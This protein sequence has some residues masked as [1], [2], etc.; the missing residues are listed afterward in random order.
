MLETG[1]RGREATLVEELLVELDELEHQSDVSQVK[2]S[3]LLFQMEDTLPPVNVIFL[4]R[5]IDRLGELADIS[6]K[7]GGRL[8]LLIAK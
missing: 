4:Y 5:I 6:Q 2:L 1:F 8:L 3:A 7:V